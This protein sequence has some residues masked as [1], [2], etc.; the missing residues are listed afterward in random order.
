[1]ALAPDKQALLAK[2]RNGGFRGATELRLTG[3]QL[4]QL[5]DELFELAP[6]LQLLDLAGNNLANL[7]E[8]FA[9]LEHLRVL[10]LLGNNFTTVPACLGQLPELY[11]LSFKSNQLSTIPEGALP[12]SLGWLILTDNRLTAL[13]VSI[14]ENKLLRKV[15]LAG[16]CFFNFFTP[17]T[18]LPPPS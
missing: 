5:P 7:P 6:T 15:M 17:P 9:T 10:F 3:C 11:M 2:L 16:K 14:G 8:R 12:P 4:D 13:P 1:M 18:R